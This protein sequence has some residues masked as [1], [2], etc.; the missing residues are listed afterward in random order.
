[1]PRVPHTYV[2]SFTSIK[3]QKEESQRKSC[4]H[5]QQRY[6]VVN[7]YPTKELQWQV[8]RRSHL[9]ITIRLQLL[10]CLEGVQWESIV[11]SPDTAYRGIHTH[12]VGIG[13]K[14]IAAVFTQLR[15]TGAR[16]GAK[17]E[18]NTYKSFNK[19]TLHSYSYHCHMH[20]KQGRATFKVSTYFK[21][22]LRSDLVQEASLSWCISGKSSHPM[23]TV[24]HLYVPHTFA[25]ALA[26]FQD[27]T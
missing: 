1:M 4:I 15:G 9:R 6:A 7:K 22:L 21:G 13:C 19:C 25:H 2:T 5:F 24:I 11:L 26:T 8:Y 27:Y 3:E 20:T 16:K 18:Q 12:L 14:V 10:P 17:L 23:L